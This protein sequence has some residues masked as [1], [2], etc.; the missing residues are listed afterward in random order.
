MGEPVVQKKCVRVSVV[1]VLDQQGVC[2]VSCVMC[3]GSPGSGCTGVL[4]LSGCIDCEGI[5]DQEGL[6]QCHMSRV[7][8]HLEVCDGSHEKAQGNHDHLE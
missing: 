8:S 5:G 4:L 2:Q 1:V 6:C 3:H 7:M